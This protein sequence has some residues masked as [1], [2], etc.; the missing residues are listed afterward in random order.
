MTLLP[1]LRRL[2]AA[3]LVSGALVVSSGPLQAQQEISPEHL[4]TARQYVDMTDAAQVYE[5]TLVEMGLRVMRLLIQEDPAISDAVVEAIQSVYDD[6]LGNRDPLYNQFARVYAIRFSQDE[7]QE[8]IDFY[9]T[10][11]GQK[12]LRHNPSINEDL[13][14]VLGIWGRNEQNVFLSRVR[15]ALRA[16]GFT[17]DGNGAAEPEEAPA[18]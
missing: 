2:T 11:V 18:E 13:Q 12:L 17:L 4:A 16:E 10:P 14:T 9:S 5:V 3:F 1:S 15:T 6:Y 8:I 7:M